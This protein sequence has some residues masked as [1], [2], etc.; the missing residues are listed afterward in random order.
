MKKDDY[1]L[2]NEDKVSHAER[3]TQLYLKSLTDPE[4]EGICLVRNK[5]SGELFVSAL[6]DSPQ[7]A[8]WLCAKFNLILLSINP[9][10]LSALDLLNSDDPPPGYDP[11][12]L[13]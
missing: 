9:D 3:V 2:N 8:H 4:W 13:S 11:P 7:D 10:D 5:E 1:S 6:T 12:E